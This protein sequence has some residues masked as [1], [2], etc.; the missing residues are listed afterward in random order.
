LILALRDEGRTVLFSSH[1]LSDAEALCTRV[2]I[3]AAGQLQADGAMTDLV[4]LTVRAW[5]M[6]LDGT[7]DELVQRLQQEEVSV[8]RLGG[9]RVQVHVPGSRAPESI[10][11]LTSAHGARV[12]SL[13]PVRETLEDVFLKHVEGKGRVMSREGA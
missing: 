1:I 9:D 5:E 7:T 2:A 13:Q 4:E 3:L 10:L 6:L 11:Q 8:T 12:L